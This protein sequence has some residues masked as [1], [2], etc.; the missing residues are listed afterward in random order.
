VKIVERGKPVM[1]SKD[2]EE[3]IRLGEEEIYN[4]T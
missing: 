2:A 1:I 3:K 4:V